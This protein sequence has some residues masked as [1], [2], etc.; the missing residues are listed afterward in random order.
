[1][2]QAADTILGSLAGTALYQR[3]LDL[4]PSTLIIFRGG[5]LPTYSRSEAA[6]LNP[7]SSHEPNFPIRRLRP[8]LSRYMPQRWR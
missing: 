4:P 7:W 3:S 8:S 5:A 2:W 1:M 6:P